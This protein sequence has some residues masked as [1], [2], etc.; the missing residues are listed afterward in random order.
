[1]ARPLRTP[2]LRLRP[3]N[4]A[5]RTLY[6]RLYGDPGVMAWVGSPLPHEAADAAFGRVLRQ[7]AVQP[8]RACY[9]ILLAR[10]GEEP[11]GLM[12]MVRDRNDPASAEVGVLLLAGA[13]AQGYAT[14]AITAL[15][16]DAFARPGLRRLWTRHRP[17]HN[18]AVAL[19]HGLGFVPDRVAAE[20]D[21]TASSRW[22]LRRAD[23]RSPQRAFAKPLSSG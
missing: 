2:R 13:Q 4:A 16:D 12:A 18:A 21:P 14:E 5:D 8:P 22:Q 6:C 19:M 7:I 11:L 10:E 1:M 23:W 3:I 9:W 15:A 20:G 17:G